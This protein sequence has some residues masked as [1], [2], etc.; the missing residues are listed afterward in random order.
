MHTDTSSPTADA[1]LRT[2]L[3]DIHFNMGGRMVEFAGWSMPVMFTGISEEH[4]HT[5]SACSVFDVSHMGRLTLTGA[6]CEL[7]LNRVCTRNLRNAEVGRSYYSHICRED[8]GIL[9]DVIVSR[10]ESHWGIVCNAANRP[11]IVAWIAEHSAGLDVQLRDETMS[12][13]MLAIQ[14]PRTLELAQRLTGIELTS[15]KRY[16]FRVYDYLSMRIIV[17]RSGYTGE[18]GLEVV[19]PATAARMLAPQLL[20]TAERP[21]PV[22]KPAGLGA[23][24]TLRIEAAMP[25][26]GH[27]LTEEVD[28]LT[29]GQGW[30]VDL[31]KDFIGASPMRR[32]R[33]QGL[34]RQ[35]IGLELEGRRIARQHFDVFDGSQRVGEV[36]SGT[37][38]PTLGKSIAM[39]FVDAGRR[40]EGG[41]L[42][43]KVGDKRIP[44]T[45]VRLPFYKR[46]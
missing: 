13:A 20:G 28:S 3:Y 37:L 6:D 40:N 19:F 10:F 12:T 27:E 30:C 15:I 4:L 38:G 18:D 14:G 31:G 5:R 36:T 17:Y 41:Q 43:V 11:K 32:L 1:L 9:D 23:R 16:H 42:E 44:A 24:D 25:L 8:G 34:S 22:I 45:V 2:P 26:Y 7:F 39:A 21:H 29:A 46:T 35:L 33:E